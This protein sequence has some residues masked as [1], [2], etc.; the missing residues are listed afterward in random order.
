M[1]CNFKCPKSE[2]RRKK[3]IR[4][5]PF[6]RAYIIAVD[7]FIFAIEQPANERYYKDIHQSEKHNMEKGGKKK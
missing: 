4:E 6:F 5:S 7:I 2:L 3:V 1:S